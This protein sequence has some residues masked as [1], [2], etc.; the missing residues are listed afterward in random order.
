MVEG[1]GD[2]Y[3]PKELLEKLKNQKFEV[4]RSSDPRPGNRAFRRS[5]YAQIKRQEKGR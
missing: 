3:Y 4:M 5:L 2:K 1:K